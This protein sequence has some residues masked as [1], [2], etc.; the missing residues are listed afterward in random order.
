MRSGSPVRECMECGNELS[1]SATQCPFCGRTQAPPPARVRHSGWKELRLKDD[2]PTVDEA[3]D[4]LY[5]ELDHA[6]QSGIRVLKIIH[7]YGSAGRG[8]RIKDEVHRTLRAYRQTRRIKRFLPGEDYSERGED[9][10]A[11][12]RLCP[13]LEKHVRSDSRNPGISFVEL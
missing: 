8:G 4:R 5:R 10:R 9:S 13:E 12:R 6:R 7:G 11:L 2:M 1:P 3:L